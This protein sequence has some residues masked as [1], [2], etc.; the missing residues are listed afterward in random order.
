MHPLWSLLGVLLLLLLAMDVLA[1]TLLPSSGAGPITAYTTSWMWK[2]LLGIH[3]LWPRHRLLQ[4]GGLAVVL[5]T[6]LLWIAMLWL[7]WLLIFC[8]ADQAVLTNQGHEPADLVSRIYFTAFSTF[9]LGIGDFVPG[10]GIW[11]VL[12]SVSVLTGLCL[13][14]LG[15]TYLVPVVQAVTAKRALAAHIYALGPDPQQMV[16]NN[17]C[18]NDSEAF[19][20]HLVS[21][22]GQIALLA[23]RHRTYPVL[24]FFH[25]SSLHNDAIASIVN[26]YETLLIIEH[27]LNDEFRP[28]SGATCPAREVISHFLQTLQEVHI[29]PVDEAPPPPPLDKLRQQGIPVVDELTFARDLA[30]YDRRRRILL[31]LVRNNGWNWQELHVQ[32]EEEAGES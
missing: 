21:L 1:T 13:L 7:G 14:S 30:D 22:T 25:T 19:E 16:L 17:C 23:Q 31:A 5:L 2:G 4:Y 11:Q 10:W 15:I 27:A 28:R 9:G 24:H 18:D 29:Q 6:L 12:T 26:L 32:Q 3:R 8:G 20:Q